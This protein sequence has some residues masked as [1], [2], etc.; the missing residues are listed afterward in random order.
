MFWTGLMR[1]QSSLLKV[2]T[3]D[4]LHQ[5]SKPCRIVRTSAGENR[6]R[7]SYWAGEPESRAS[8]HAIWRR[9][10]GAAAC[11]HCRHVIHQFAFLDTRT[12]G[13][14]NAVCQPVSRS[15]PHIKLGALPP[16]H[17][18]RTSGI[19]VVRSG[20]S[21]MRD[22]GLFFLVDQSMICRPSV[23]LYIIQPLFRPVSLPWKWLAQVYALGY[24]PLLNSNSLGLISFHFTGEDRI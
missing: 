5:H 20:T 8:Q 9:I 2:A 15:A 10:P 18:Q 23:C 12:N 3:S 11:Q 24:S 13:T 7:A 17:L 19:L 16:G 1:V 6:R 22:Y 21:M 4:E 14:S